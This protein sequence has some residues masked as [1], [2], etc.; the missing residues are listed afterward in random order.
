MRSFYTFL[1][2]ALLVFAMA[3][4]CSKSDDITDMVDDV[5]Q[6]DDD[7]GNATDDDPGGDS[8]LTFESVELQVE[9]PAGS[10]LDLGTTTLN[11]LFETFDV[12]SGGQATASLVK[13]NRSFAYLTDANGDIVLM[14]FVSRDYP[15]LDAEATLEFA[16][17][18]ALGTV[19]QLPEIREKYFG[20]FRGLPETA[21]LVAALEA[22]IAADPTF[23]QS[24]QFPVWAT[25]KARD[26][27]GNKEVIDVTNAILLEDTKIKSGVA[28]TSDE[29]NIFA[30]NVLNFKRRRARAYFYKYARRMSGESEFEEIY[31]P[32]GIPDADRPAEKDIFIS[33]TTGVT[34]AQGNLIELARG[35]GATL[36]FTK[37]GPVNLPLTGQE[38]AAK[39][40]VRVVGPGKRDH[41]LTDEE[42]SEVIKLNLETLLLDAVIP[43]ISNGVSAADAIDNDNAIT[44][45]QESANL[46][47]SSSPAAYNALESGDLKTAAIEF[48]WAALENGAGSELFWKGIIGL[49]QKAGV[50]N[51]TASRFEKVIGKLSGPLAIANAIITS[52]DIARVV[53]DMQ[54]SQK[55]EFFDFTVSK[56]TVRINPRYKG[57]LK[58][59]KVGLKA[60]LLDDEEITPGEYTFNWS[61]EGLY[62]DFETASTTEEI[63]YQSDGNIES[64][65][66]DAKEIIR[67]EVFRE[68]VA[69]GKDSAT[70]NIS[71][72][73]FVIRPNGITVEG[74]DKLSMGLYDL[75]G[76][77]MS[78]TDFG[79]TYKVHWEI[80]GE[81]GK[82]NGHTN[83][84]TLEDGNGFTVEYHC[85]D[86][87]SEE[88][89]ENVT[90]TIYYASEIDEN[91]TLSEYELYDEIE[92]TI[93]IQN[94]E[95]I[96]RYYVPIDVGSHRD[97]SGI[98]HN[99]QVWSKFAWH[100]NNATADIPEGY[101]VEKY[102]MHIMERIPDVI[103]S[104]S[105]T[106]D[107]WFPEEVGEGMELELRCP[108]SAISGP[109]SG[110]VSAWLSSTLARYATAKGFAQVTVYLKPK[111]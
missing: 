85:F 101:E 30:V 6:T 21:E 45:L 43:I 108:V 65:P 17:Y 24:G 5:S 18:Y 37:N 67:V 32:R 27:V 29:T 92:A 56:G 109:N 3:P 79:L 1:I 19:F 51:L 84:L 34:S 78:R 100:T 110:N 103:P 39:Y 68:G 53:Y 36:G 96:L 11:V 58:G 102:S 49:F 73:E 71:D 97:Q 55:L 25:E 74:D 48:L 2:L 50:T 77:A 15:R 12:S 69:V 41:N 57:I 107:T 47:L 87:E 8:E 106:S 46:I 22:E 40:R 91:G 83:T 59:K 61:T 81:F 60:D 89:V 54:T 52:S 16:M 10:D 111:N 62:G 42:R 14:G 31:N 88:G 44:T 86:K 66:A 80:G 76:Q 13:D 23:V 4:G 20:E 105:R 70:I 9:M 64:L 94:K 93:N 82:L 35:N 26:L 90:A 104:C 98:F 75:D 99:A 63:T 33:P 95:D 38:E 28:I 72:K 7:D